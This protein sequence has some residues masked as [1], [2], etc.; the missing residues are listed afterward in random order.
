MIQLSNPSLRASDEDTFTVGTAEKALFRAVIL[1]AFAD[2]VGYVTDVD[3]DRGGLKRTRTRMMLAGRSF[4]LNGSHDFSTV[5]EYAD[6]EPGLVRSKAE[7][8]QAAGWPREM[9]PTR[10]ST[11]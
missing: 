5:C 9:V 7:E 4:L 3:L 8:M 10:R 6:Y 2:A 11:K 1:R